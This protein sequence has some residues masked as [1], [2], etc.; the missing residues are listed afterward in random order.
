M[1]EHTEECPVVY[2]KCPWD[3]REI[4]SESFVAKNILGIVAVL[5]SVLG[6]AYTLGSYSVRV[7]N[8]EANDVRLE[9]IIKNIEDKG[10][11]LSQKLDTT[12]Q[13]HSTRISQ[14]ENDMRRTDNSIADIKA[15]IKMI[16]QWVQE[17][18]QKS[19]GK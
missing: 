7:S 1:T 18:K 4:P 3:G 2:N 19:G 13:L 11:V 9:S 10:T 6:W 15:D 16:A 14:L 8:L 12:V 5:I 17:Q